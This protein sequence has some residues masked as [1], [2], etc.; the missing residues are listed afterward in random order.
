[1][2]EG[3][4]EMKVG[5]EPQVQYCWGSDS[6]YQAFFEQHQNPTEPGLSTKTQYG[7]SLV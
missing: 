7:Y 4:V 2:M 1:M 5:A 3:E 6:E